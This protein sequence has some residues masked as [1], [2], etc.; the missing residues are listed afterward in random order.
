MTEPSGNGGSEAS[1]GSSPCGLLGSATV[2]DTFTVALALPPGPAL[3]PAL[4]ALRPDVEVVVAPYSEPEEVRSARG[5]NGGR[6][7]ASLP[8][9]PIDDATLEVLARA[10]VLLALDVPEDL[11]T[12]APR[13]R[14]VQSVNAG[15]DRVHLQGLADAGIRLSNASGLGA[16][17]IAEFVMGRLLQV[18]KNLRLF[19]EQ[20]GRQEW[21]LRF[22]TELPAAPSASSGSVPS[23]GRWPGGHEPST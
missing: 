10:D 8:P 19:D 18:W 4:Q 13:L 17:S 9:P 15:F 22:G 5:R 6:R 20:Q 11:G 2:E 23:A 21:S 3:V 12:L 16:A 14:W 1:H 7:P